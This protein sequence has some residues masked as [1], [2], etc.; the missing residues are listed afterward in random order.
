MQM[1][2]QYLVLVDNK[3][4]SLNKTTIIFWNSLIYLYIFHWY[5]VLFCFIVYFSCIYKVKRWIWNTFVFS[6]IIG[7]QK[8]FRSCVIVLS[9]Y[10]PFFR[11]FTACFLYLK[12]WSLLN[13]IEIIIDFINGSV[14]F[15]L[16]YCLRKKQWKF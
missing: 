10:C 14:F 13:D 7:V 9:F 15:N 5:V 4:E 2:I 8:L 12:Y 16:L 1:N 3:F 6:F 11:F